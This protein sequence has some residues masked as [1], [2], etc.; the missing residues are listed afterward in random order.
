MNVYVHRCMNMST[1]NCM[2]G[3]DVRSYCSYVS[4]ECMYVLYILYVSAFVPTHE[5]ICVWSTLCT[6]LIANPKSTQSVSIYF[7]A[8]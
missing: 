6:K 3:Y 2:E 7:T 8:T 4:T 5:Y 1:M